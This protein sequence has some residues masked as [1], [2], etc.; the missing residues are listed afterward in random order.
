VR[1]SARGPAAEG[2]ICLRPLRRAEVMTESAAILIY[3]ADSHPAA[4]L[5]PPLDDP[6]R[7]AF[8]RWMSYV[9]AQIYALIWVTDD[10]GR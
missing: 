9:S 7:P 3:L 1:S 2:G 8:L 10:P 6:R 5:S 4:N